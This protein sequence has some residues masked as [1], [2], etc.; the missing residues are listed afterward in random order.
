LLN[1]LGCLDVPTSGT[2]RIAGQELSGLSD[3]ALTRLRRDRI[4]FVFQQFGLVPTLTVAENVALPAL[5]SR[6]QAQRRVEE[7]L[8]KVGLEPRRNHRP[9]QLS[10]GEMQRV[11][12]ARALVNE[13]EI[14]LADEP[15]GNLDSAT[16]EGIIALFRQLQGEGLTVVVVTHNA[17]LAEAAERRLE[18]R[19]GRLVSDG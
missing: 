9:H 12:I 8:A 14:L 18:L 10:G 4:G 7:L 5:F 17:P 16:G 13:P 19:D 2:L 6:R 15:T 3:A 11:A 1:L